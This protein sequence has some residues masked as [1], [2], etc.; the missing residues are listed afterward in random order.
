[1]SKE[2]PHNK[3]IYTSIKG[4]LL[5]FLPVY[6]LSA[7]IFY[8]MLGV[9]WPPNVYQ[10]LMLGG[11]TILTIIYLVLAYSNSYYELTKHEIKHTKGK[12]ILYYA[13]KDILYIDELHSSKKTTIRFVTRLGDERY[14][15]HDPKRLV[16]TEMLLKTPHRVSK[17][18]IKSQFPKLNL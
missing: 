6:L 17:E 10:Y 14:L 12:E 11:W 13:Y 18:A 8:L 1:M 3:R 2:T 5:V 7:I 16:Y 4:L 15:T 9:I